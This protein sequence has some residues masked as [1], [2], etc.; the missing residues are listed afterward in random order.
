[1]A[2]ELNNRQDVGPS[3]WGVALG[4]TETPGLVHGKSGVVRW[5]STDGEAETEARRDGGSLSETDK[6][7]WRG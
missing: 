3:G 2:S 4:S 5:L 7:R 1:M 6:K